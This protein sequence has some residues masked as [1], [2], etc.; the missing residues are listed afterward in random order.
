MVALLLVILFSIATTADRE[1]AIGLDQM[2]ASE[3]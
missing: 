2:Q 1:W 3:V